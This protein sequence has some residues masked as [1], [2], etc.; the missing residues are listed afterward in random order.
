VLL[1]EADASGGENEMDILQHDLGQICSYLE[2]EIIRV[3][4][5]FYNTF[6]YNSFVNIS[7]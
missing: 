6:V 5:N 4:Y 7:Q 2:C 3:N 1:G